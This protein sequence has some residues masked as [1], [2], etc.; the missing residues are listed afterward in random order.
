MQ[1]VMNTHTNYSA[2][3]ILPSTKYLAAAKIHL[4]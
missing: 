2:G 4:Q 3:L 1:I